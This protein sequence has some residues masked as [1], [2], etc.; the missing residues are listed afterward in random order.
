MKQYLLLLNANIRH[1]LMMIYRFAPSY[2]Y[3]LEKSGLSQASL[4]DYLRKLEKKSIIFKDNSKYR[5]HPNFQKK[6]T[7]LILGNLTKILLVIVGLILNKSYQKNAK[8]H[9]EEIESLNK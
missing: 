8:L 5:I 3:L 4:D 9:L 1:L 7:K 2:D 6:L